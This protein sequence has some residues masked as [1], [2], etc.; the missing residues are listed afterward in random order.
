MTKTAKK[1]PETQHTAARK[2]FIGGG[3]GVYTCGVC[4]R[5]T[6]AVDLDAKSVDLCAECY[7]LAGIENTISDNGVDSEA[8]QNYFTEAREMLGRLR[9]KGID[10]SAIWASVIDAVETP[11]AAVETPAFDISARTRGEQGSVVGPA[12]VE[13]YERAVAETPVAP[14]A[15]KLTQ[16]VWLVIGQNVWGR[17]YT[18]DQAFAACGK[19]KHFAAYVSS[20]PWVY[21]DEMGRVCYVPAP[22]A[23]PLARPYRLVA[24][25]VQKGVHSTWTVEGGAS[26]EHRGTGHLHVLDARY[27]TR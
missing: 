22:G 2:R 4:Q 16:F 21:V 23:D 25:K 24:V 9:A 14:V 18:F 17:G 13:D 12:S 10:V 1:T 5:S 15:E 7:T 19:P 27:P 20:D 11:V 3:G 26:V 6:R 8:A